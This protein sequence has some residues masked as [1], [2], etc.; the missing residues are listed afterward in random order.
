[1]SVLCTIRFHR[2]GTAKEKSIKILCDSLITAASKN[3]ADATVREKQAKKLLSF[4]NLIILA[5]YVN[6]M[7][8]S[9]KSKH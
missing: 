2:E 4:Y 8:T 6:A 1:M 5:A 9:T 3:I 7:D